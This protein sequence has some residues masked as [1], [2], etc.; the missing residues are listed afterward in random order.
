MC[1]RIFYALN[2][3]WINKE[4]L[5]NYLNDPHLQVNILL[6]L[7]LS[8]LKLEGIKVLVLDFDGVLSAFGEKIPRP[9]LN[10]W[11]KSSVQ[12]FGFGKVFILT[13]KPNEFRRLYFLEH[14]PGIEFIEVQRKKPYPDGLIQILQ[15]VSI[16]PKELLMVDDRLLTGILA[17]VLVHAQAILVLKPWISWSHRPIAELFFIFLRTL[18]HVIF[19]KL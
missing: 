8:T 17:A 14:F 10:E 7:E 2:K 9:E 4:K 18:E 13:N 19:K 12:T 11:L 6:D 15:K 3:A 1:K 5:K 16:E